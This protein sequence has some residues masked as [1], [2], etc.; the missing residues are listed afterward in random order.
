MRPLTAVALVLVAVALVVV[1]PAGA[2]NPK[3]KGSVG[4]SFTISMSV[5]PKKAGTYDITVTD[6]A[7]SHNFHI[8]GP[9]L[10]KANTSKVKVST[11][12][13]ATGTFTLK[14]LK[15]RAGK[16]YRFVCDPHA[17]SMKG[18]FKVTA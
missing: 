9:G 17:S 13:A 5:K 11:S 15:L 2:A 18:S 3:L 16:T 1:L 14:A 8:S 4:P 7:A 6:K 12:V 10:P